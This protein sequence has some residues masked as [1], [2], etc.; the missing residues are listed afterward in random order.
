[1]AEEA[2][3]P[4][5]LRIYYWPMLGRAGAMV[6]MCE[7]A[8]APYKF[9]S[10]FAELQKVCAAFGDAT[11][12][13]EPMAAFAPP[14]LRDGGLRISQSGACVMYVGEKLGL[15]RGV[16]QAAVAMKHMSDVADMLVECDRAFSGAKDLPPLGAAEALRAF[17]SGRFSQWVAVI[18]ASIAGP[19]YFGPDPTYVDFFLANAVDWLQAAW[20]KGLPVWDTSPKVVAVAQSIRDLPSYIGYTGPLKTVKDGYNGILAADIA[21]VFAHSVQKSPLVRWVLKSVPGGGSDAGSIKDGA[22]AGQGYKQPQLSNFERVEEEMPTETDLTD[23]QVILHHCFVSVDP[24]V[25]A[26]MMG[27]DRVGETVVAG[28]AGVIVASRSPKF[29]VGDFA[30]ANGGAANASVLDGAKVR[31]ISADPES[32]VEYDAHSIPLSA[33]LGILGMP[34]VTSW[35]ATVEILG[36]ELQGKTIVVTGAAGAVGSAGASSPYVC[37][38]LRL[39]CLHR[40]RSCGPVHTCMYV[41]MYSCMCVQSCC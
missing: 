22:P 38:Y 10:D 26:Y 6:R 37:T 19:Y 31:K 36:R 33:S 29:Q 30:V 39:H 17:T 23:G 2:E 40:P 24:Y 1:M 9:I 4:P 21:A 16:P 3:A 13:E 7:H 27:P 34:G 18:N 14:V 15:H 32:E 11:T 25:P 41:C 20:F 35:L 8:G 28:T 12:T 5:P